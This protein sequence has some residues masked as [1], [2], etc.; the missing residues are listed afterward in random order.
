MVSFDNL[1][2]ILACEAGQ[3]RNKLT[4]LHKPSKPVFVKVL[5]DGLGRGFDE[6]LKLG[7]EIAVISPPT[8]EQVCQFCMKRMISVSKNLKN[9][10]R[11][12][13]GSE[14]TRHPFNDITDS[15]CHRCLIVRSVERKPGLVQ[16]QICN[17]IDYRLRLSVVKKWDKHLQRPT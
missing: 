6:S 15:S 4:Y 11:Y 16:S 9:R 13:N 5:T 8:F 2:T 7:L 10:K 14:C 1:K 17:N 12:F 3:N